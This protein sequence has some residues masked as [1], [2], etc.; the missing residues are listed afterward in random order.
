[1]SLPD[2]SAPSAFTSAPPP[3]RVIETQGA[4]DDLDTVSA[5]ALLA[6]TAPP[7]SRAVLYLRVS[8]KG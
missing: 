6:A 7:G 8:S 1:M 4:M 5:D 2:S 3:L